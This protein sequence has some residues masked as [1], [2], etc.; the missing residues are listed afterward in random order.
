MIF[1]LSLFVGHIQNTIFE[2]SYNQNYTTD[3]TLYSIERPKLAPLADRIYCSSQLIVAA[4]AVFS[5]PKKQPSADDGTG[6][7]ITQPRCSYL[8]SY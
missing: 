3:D 1:W 8:R 6:R 5:A 7:K 4:C 2:T